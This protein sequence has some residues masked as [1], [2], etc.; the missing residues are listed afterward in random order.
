MAHEYAHAV[1]ACTPT[2]PNREDWH[3]PDP[4]HQN[5][6]VDGIH[7]AIGQVFKASGGWL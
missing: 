3:E 6:W 5:W 2:A 7:P 4:M 1:Q